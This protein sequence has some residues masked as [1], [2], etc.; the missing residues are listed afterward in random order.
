MKAKFVTVRVYEASYH[1]VGKL[2]R[3]RKTGKFW[4][5]EEIDLAIELSNAGYTA[6]EIA[7]DL[8]RTAFAV[9][10]KL[11]AIRHDQELIESLAK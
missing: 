2:N 8:G 9:S 3:K 5:A 7:K 1:Q 6:K 4:T 10:N 11:A